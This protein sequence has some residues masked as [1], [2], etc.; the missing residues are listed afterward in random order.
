MH[1]SPAPEFNAV[2]AADLAPVRSPRL[3]PNGSPTLSMLLGFEV[4]LSLCLEQGSFGVFY[5]Q[6]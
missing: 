2:H 5:V 4:P 3:P 1:S 6:T